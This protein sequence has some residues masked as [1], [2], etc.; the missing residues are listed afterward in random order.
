MAAWY[1]LM[2]MHFNFLKRILYSIT[3]VAASFSKD[4]IPER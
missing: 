1:I 3:E 2:V 4:C